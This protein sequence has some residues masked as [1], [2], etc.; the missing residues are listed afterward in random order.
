M[1]TALR[2]GKDWDVR[3]LAFSLDQAHVQEGEPAI[4]DRPPDERG[5]GVLPLTWGIAVRDTFPDAFFDFHIA[6]FAARFDDERKIG[7]LD[8]V[9]DVAANIGLDVDA[10]AKEVDSGRP[11]A[12]LAAEHTEAVTTWGTFGVPTFAD[13]DNAAFVRVMDRNRVDDLERVLDLLEFSRLN[14][15]KRPRIPR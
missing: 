14:E 6:V 9:H 11:L 13:G 12:A 3:F 7:D 5:S 2:D 1:V 15:F 8:V 4:W 10:V